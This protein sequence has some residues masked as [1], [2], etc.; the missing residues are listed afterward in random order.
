MEAC[1][2]KW[3]NNYKIEILVTPLCLAVIHVILEHIL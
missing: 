1:Y 2:E 3:L